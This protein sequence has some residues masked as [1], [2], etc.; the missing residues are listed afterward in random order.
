MADSKE[1]GS[2]NSIATI[3]YRYPL[4][5]CM[6]SIIFIYLVWLS[7]GGVERGEQRRLEGKTSVFIELDSPHNNEDKQRIVGAVEVE[8]VGIFTTEEESDQ[9]Q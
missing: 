4:F 8:Q 7:T 9:D 5:A 2:G 6:I 1:G 3:F